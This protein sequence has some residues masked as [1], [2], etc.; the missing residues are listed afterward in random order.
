MLRLLADENFHGDVIRGLLLREPE[1][2][3]LTVQRVGLGAAQDPDI[4][5]WAAG[6]GRIVL[7]HDRSTMT[8]FANERVARREAMPGLFIVD[9]RYPVGLAIEEVL[10]VASCSEMDEWIDRVVF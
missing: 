4:L 10:I 3:I 1:L 5:A 6:D 9:D 2:D 7:S 8:R